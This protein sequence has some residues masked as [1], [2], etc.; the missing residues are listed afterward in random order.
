MV[1]CFCAVQLASRGVIS[2]MFS[3]CFGSVEGEG[4]FMVGDVDISPY[5]VSLQYTPMVESPGHPH[6][7]AVNLV[8]IGVGSKGLRLGSVSRLRYPGLQVHDVAFVCSSTSSS[9][10][11]GSIFDGANGSLS[12]C[13]I[14]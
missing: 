2:D 8:A 13:N 12:G 7:I 1:C 14:L 3:L 5:N 4:A 11:G 10:F 9:R 6:Y